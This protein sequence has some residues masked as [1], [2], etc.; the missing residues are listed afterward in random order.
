MI[1]GEFP[2][3]VSFAVGDRDAFAEQQIDCVALV[4]GVAP[5][6]VRG[7]TP[8]LGQDTMGVGA[9]PTRGDVVAQRLHGG[10][11]RVGEA[12]VTGPV[13]VRQRFENGVERSPVEALDRLL[14]PLAGEGG[15]HV[16]EF[17]SVSEAPEV[18]P[19]GGNALDVLPGTRG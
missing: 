11:D 10:S 7:H 12:D 17:A 14:Q 9:L 5:C 1:T 2:G 4:S 18:P 19:V 8:F 15:A 3:Q 16:D 6:E 13:T